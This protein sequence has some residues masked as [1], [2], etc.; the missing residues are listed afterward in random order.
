M[1]Q[2][3][4][5]NPMSAVINNGFWGEWFQLERSTR[6]GCPASSLIFVN[7]IEILGIK[8]K[9]NPM[10]QGIESHVFKYDLMQYADDI[11]VALEPTV[12]NVNNLLEEMQRFC[13]F[14]WLRINYEK[15]AILRIGPLRNS[16]VKFYT[17]KPIAWADEGF[18][19]ILGVK[20]PANPNRLL[21]LNFG[22]KIDG[23]TKKWAGRNP[24]LMGRVMLINTLVICQLM[25]LFL[26]LPSPEQFY[27]NLFKTMTQFCMG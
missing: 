1:I 16:E 27:V 2:T 4:Y 21:D 19:S 15:S 7:I 24:T 25:F 8:I 26:V 20:F 18:I 11:W 12:N 5:K 23:I 14:S 6:Q 3:L 22:P 10:I 9:A 17:I 13:D